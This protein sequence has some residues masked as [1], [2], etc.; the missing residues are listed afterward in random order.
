MVSTKLVSSDVNEIESKLKTFGGDMVRIEFLE[1]CLK[2]LIPNDAKR[3]CH[4]KLADMYAY[5]LM[6]GLAGKNMEAAADC[7][8]TYGDKINFYIKEIAFLIKIGDYLMIDKAFKKA[9]MCSRTIQEKE[10]VKTKIKEMM[11]SQAKD[12]ESRNKRSNAAQI[13]ERLLEMPITNDEERKQLIE[14]LGALNSKLGKIREAMRYETMAKRPL[15]PRK[16]QD[17]DSGVRKVSFE[18]L[19]IDSV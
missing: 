6:W 5:K 4:L 16:S 14:K 9:M 15:E 18:D 8:T 19:G 7:A 2:Q 3:F 13:Y 12:Y 17:A 1:N 11:F 10:S